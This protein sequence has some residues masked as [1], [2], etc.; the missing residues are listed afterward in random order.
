MEIILV[1]IV[2]AVIAAVIAPSRGRSA[3]AWFAICFLLSP[4]ALIA[5]LALPNLKEAPLPVYNAPPASPS[6]PA[7]RFIADE[8]KCPMCAEMVKREAKICRFCGHAFPEPVQPEALPQGDGVIRTESEH[9]VTVYVLNG[10]R[11]KSF[12]EARGLQ[13]RLRKPG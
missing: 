2:V 10:R 11:F 4:L 12:D 1:W 9:G 6:S 7:Q 13:D 3:G 5:L 8:K